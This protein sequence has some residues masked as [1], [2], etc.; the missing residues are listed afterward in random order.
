MWVDRF[1]VAPPEIGFPY[2]AVLRPPKLHQATENAY[3][4][5]IRASGVISSYVDLP[6]DEQARPRV[7]RNDRVH[8]WRAG[9]DT[10]P[11]RPALGHETHDLIPEVLLE[12][13]SVDISALEILGITDKRDEPEPNRGFE[14][15][16]GIFR[17]EQAPCTSAATARHAG[18]A[19]G[20]CVADVRS[21]VCVGGSRAARLRAKLQRH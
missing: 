19:A 6:V 2:H 13:P 4:S 11:P 7:S 15:L 14:S 8:G 5:E 17:D 12:V 3:V 16:G 10:G 21:R 20:V 18:H 1:E 9:H